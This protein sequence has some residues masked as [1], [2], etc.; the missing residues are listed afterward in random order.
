MTNSKQN[1]TVLLLLTITEYTV[2]HVSTPYSSFTDLM[3]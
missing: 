1:K 2:C 3:R